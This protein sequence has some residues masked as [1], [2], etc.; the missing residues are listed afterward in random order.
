MWTKGPLT[1]LIDLRD[2]PHQSYPFKKTAQPVQSVNTRPSTDRAQLGHTRAWRLVSLATTILGLCTLAYGDEF[3]CAGVAQPKVESR[4][5]IYLQVGL[6]IAADLGV[7]ELAF[8]KGYVETDPLLGRDRGRRLLVG[9]ALVVG[10]SEGVRFVEAHDHK[11]WA[12]I[13]KGATWAGRA[14]AIGLGIHN[15]TGPRAK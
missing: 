1:V 7:S 3:P 8:S 12:W 9:A 4:K 10:V 13:I 5:S 15:A 2:E 14:Y 11:T 6:P